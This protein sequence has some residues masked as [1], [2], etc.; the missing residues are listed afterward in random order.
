MAAV[1]AAALAL[2]NPA[3][4][5]AL[6]TNVM[7][8]DTPNLNFFAPIKAA[9]LAFIKSCFSIGFLWMPQSGKSKGWQAT[10]IQGKKSIPS[11]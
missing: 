3:F 2:L 4:S 5:L 7:S 9:A 1:K 6:F 10:Y 8:L 11:V